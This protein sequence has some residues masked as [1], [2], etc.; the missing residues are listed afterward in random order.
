MMCD[1]SLQEHSNTVLEECFTNEHYFSS[2]IFLRKIIG[3]DFTALNEVITFSV[4]E[5]RRCANNISVL[6]DNIVESVEIFSIRISSNQVPINQLSSF[7]TTVNINDRSSKLEH[8]YFEHY[9]V[10][11]NGHSHRNHDCFQCC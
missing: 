5:V 9:F 3:V 1:I 10:I 8:C 2:S 6:T 4:G 7:G 11:L